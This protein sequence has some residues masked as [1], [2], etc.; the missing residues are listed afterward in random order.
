MCHEHLTAPVAGGAGIAEEEVET[1]GAGRSIPGFLARPES[2][3][4]P[5]VLVIHD[6]WGANPFYHDFA[7]RLAGE[8][9]VA[10]LPDLF[11]REGPIP[12][13]EPEAR[14]TRRAKWSQTAA[15]EDVAGAMNWL[16]SNPA[17]SGKIATIGFCMGGTLVFLQAARDPLPD[18]SIAYYGFPK[19]DPTPLAP[20]VPLDEASQVKSKLLAFWGDQDH[21]C[22]MEK[23]ALY[24][25]ALDAA[26]IDYEAVIYPGMPHGFITFDPNSPNYEAA[27]DSWKRSLAFLEHTVAA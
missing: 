25:E 8:G 7:R 12:V 23:V 22:G 27:Q 16:K 13:N 2:G 4:G 10:L 1:P 3:T 9:Y 18:A 19:P 11:V 20:H 26:K 17:C 14:H 21:G 5:G 6:I 24:G 15:L